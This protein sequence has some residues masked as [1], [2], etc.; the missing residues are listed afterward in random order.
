MLAAAGDKRRDFQALGRRLRSGASRYA[1]SP[2]CDFNYCFYLDPEVEMA[3]RFSHLTA[4]DAADLAVRAGVKQL[5]LTHI[6]RRNRGKDVLAEARAIFPNT[7]VARD[8]ERFQV[9]DSLLNQPL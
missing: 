3:R 5:I 8:L 1:M 7:M 4:R 2:E 6:S 9:G